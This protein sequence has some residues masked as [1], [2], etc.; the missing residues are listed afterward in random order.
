METDAPILT[1]YDD[2]SLGAPVLEPVILWSDCTRNWPR[3]VEADEF[4]SYQQA[5]PIGPA[6]ANEWIII[7]PEK[8]E[9]WGHCL[10]LAQTRPQEIKTPPR[11]IFWPK[12]L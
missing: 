7:R 2:V 6:S 3:P 11:P 4:A 10:K 1:L 8:R 9:Q 5:G 12:C